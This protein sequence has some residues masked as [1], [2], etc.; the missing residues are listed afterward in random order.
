MAWALFLRGRNTKNYTSWTPNNRI[1][2]EIRLD[3]TFVTSD[4]F[5]CEMRC[6]GFSSIEYDELLNDG[7]VNFG[8]SYVKTWPRIYQVEY[9]TEDNGVL[10]IKFAKTET[11]HFSVLSLTKQGEDIKCD[12]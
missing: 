2:E 4:Q 7:N 8:N 9:E 5:W 3:S 1:L 11:K 6:F 10:V 12:C